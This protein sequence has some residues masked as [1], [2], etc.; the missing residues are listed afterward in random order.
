MLMAP[1]VE[2]VRHGVSS[3][4]LI[5]KFPTGPPLDITHQL[6]AINVTFRI[7]LDVKLDLCRCLHT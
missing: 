2:L 5:I 4:R 6:A 1:S 7:H 3:R